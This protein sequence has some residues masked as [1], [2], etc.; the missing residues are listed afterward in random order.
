MRVE[1]W[2]KENVYVYIVLVLLL[3]IVYWM[4]EK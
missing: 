3:R 2:S 1:L 4:I